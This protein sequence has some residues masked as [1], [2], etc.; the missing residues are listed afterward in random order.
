MPPSNSSPLEMKV[1]GGN[2]R[3]D[4]LPSVGGNSSLLQKCDDTSEPCFGGENISSNK[5]Y[6]DVTPSVVGNTNA[7]KSGCSAK[8]ETSFILVWIL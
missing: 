5:F 4:S 8:V 3:H 7:C 6:E 1:K 2:K